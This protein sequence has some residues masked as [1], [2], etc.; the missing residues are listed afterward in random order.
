MSFSVEAAGPQPIMPWPPV[1]NSLHLEWR[2]FPPSAGPRRS[3]LRR[4]RSQ[5]QAHG[6]AAQ[7]ERR[8][9]GACFSSMTNAVRSRADVAQYF[10]DQR[11]FFSRAASTRRKFSARLQ[12]PAGF[13]YASR[14][15]SLRAASTWCKFSASLQ[16]P[17]GFF[18]AISLDTTQVQRKFQGPAGFFFMS[19]LDT[20]QLLPTVPHWVTGGRMRWRIEEKTD[21]FFLGLC[22]RRVWLILFALQICDFCR[23]D[24]GLVVRFTCVQSRLHILY[25]RCGGENLCLYVHVIVCHIYIYSLPLFIPWFQVIYD[26][27]T[28]CLHFTC[29]SG[30]GRL[31]TCLRSGLLQVWF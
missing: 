10:K 12:G 11:A 17:A 30:C 4:R 5:D 14:A 27:S 7:A 18:F 29:E 22:A 9:R 23:S 6:T 25:Y 3:H 20:M 28:V 31:R 8:R 21:V 16:G 24:R 2:F 1:P 15:S 26:I 13:F 19:S